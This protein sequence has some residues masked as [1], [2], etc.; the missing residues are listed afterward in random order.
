VDAAEDYVVGLGPLGR[1]LGELEG[2]AGVVG[3]GYHVVALVVVA[4]DDEAA[5]QL[6]PR[7]LD[8][9]GQLRLRHPEVV[10]ERRCLCRSR[11]FQNLKRRGHLP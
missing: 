5:P 9:L 6:A 4:E 8:A 3:V 11:V 1:E 2:V 7:G 10:F